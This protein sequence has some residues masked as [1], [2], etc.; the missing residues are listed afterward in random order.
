MKN[1]LSV[2]VLVIFAS[3]ITTFMVIGYVWRFEYY[4]PV[5]FEDVA[6]DKALLIDGVESYLSVAVFLLQ[7]KSRSIAYEVEYPSPASQEE[8]R[9]PFNITTVK[10]MGFSHL[11]Y[12]GE[13]LVEFF[14]DRLVGVR[15]FT[16]SVDAY[17]RQ[18]LFQER[19]DL[20]AQ[21]EILSSKNTRVWS[22]TD[23]AGRAYIGW[24]DIRLAK[25]MEIWIK[26]YS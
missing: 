20:L 8:N 3:L 5:S 12:T 25:E 11:G 26:R 16:S 22:A 2:K 19:L 15:F 4:L 6:P 23:Y 1:L 7:L 14:N 21:P 24:E 10:I 17:K 13:L 18:L 9:P